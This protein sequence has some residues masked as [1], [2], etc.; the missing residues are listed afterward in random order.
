[1][2]KLLLIPLIL[3]TVLDLIFCSCAGSVSTSSLATKTYELKIALGTPPGHPVT[4]TWENWV[5]DIEA[6]TGGRVTCKIFNSGSLIP[7]DQVQ[8]ALVSGIADCGNFIPANTRGV[9]NV[10]EAFE[11][12]G[13]GPSSGVSSSLA[14]WEAYKTTPEA[15]AEAKGLKILWLASSGSA[16]IGTV[17][18]PIRTLEDIKGME[19]RGLGITT[20]ALKA[21]GA[22]GVSMPMSDTYPNLQ[23]KI[24]EGAVSPFDS[25]KSMRFA[26]VYRYYTICYIYSSYRFYEAMS[27]RTWNSLPPDLQG[28]IADVSDG[29]ALKMGQNFDASN[30]AGYQVCLDKNI[31]LIRLSA[32]ENSRWQ[33]SWAPLR[34]KWA[35]DMTAKGLP[36]KELVNKPASLLAKY[37]AQYPDPVGLHMK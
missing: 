2:R 14:I 21:L 10:L 24:V 19:I 6:A 15:Q 9:F 32:A 12:P 11:L 36:G 33:N 1:M 23:K 4:L 30:E 34:E 8:S 27:L 29:Y 17:D 18:Q 16:H 25:V 28:I 7:E 5:K 22:T 37:Y 35:A 26:D 20:D 31:E 3:I 13:N